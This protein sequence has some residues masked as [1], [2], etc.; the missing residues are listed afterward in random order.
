MLAAGILGDGSR[1]RTQDAR[2]PDT[3]S[4]L[5]Q[6]TRHTLTIANA[7][8]SRGVQG[9]ARHQI[10][11]ASRK[12]MQRFNTQVYAA[13]LTTWIFKEYFSCVHIFSESVNNF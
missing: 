13:Y 12:Y 7:A 1:L 2:R 10:L 8:S 4:S 5:R 11:K 3:A 6:I 9:S